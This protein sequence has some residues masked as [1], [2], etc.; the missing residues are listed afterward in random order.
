MGFELVAKFADERPRRPGSGIAERA[1][2]I[3]SDVAG[4]VENKIQITLFAVAVL[5]AVKNF[6]HPVAALAAWAALTACLVGKKPREVQRRPHH[7]GGFV[8]D[9]DTAG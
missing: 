3:A 4:D 7:T 8:H 2:R 5:N 6:F 1:N 9:D